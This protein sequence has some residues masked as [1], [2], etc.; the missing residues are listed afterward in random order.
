MMFVE[1][2]APVT[3]KGPSSAKFGK[4]HSTQLPPEPRLWTRNPAVHPG[5][6]GV[7][8]NGDTQKWLAMKH[9]ELS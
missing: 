3:R 5:R 8:I 7:S 1:S 4:A 9:M 6:W 2:R